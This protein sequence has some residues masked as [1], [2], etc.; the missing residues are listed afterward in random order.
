MIKKK[1]LDVVKM[2][3]LGMMIS[4]IRLDYKPKNNEELATL[5]QEHFNVICTEKDIINYENVMVEED[6]ET[7][8]RRHSFFHNFIR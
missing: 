2:N 4:I 1:I 6:F 7:E 3:E 8:S 5:I